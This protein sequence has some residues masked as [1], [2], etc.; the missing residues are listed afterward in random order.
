[1]N[2]CIYKMDGK[3]LCVPWYILT[4]FVLGWWGA[5]LACYMVSGRLTVNWVCTHLIPW[6]WFCTHTLSFFNPW[7]KPNIKHEYTLFFHPWIETSVTLA[8]ITLQKWVGI[9][10]KVGANML[11]ANLI[12][13]EIGTILLYCV[14][15]YIPC[16]NISGEKILFLNYNED[17]MTFGLM[18]IKSK[19]HFMLL[20][21]TAL[22][23]FFYLC[24]CF[25]WNYWCLLGG[26]LYLHGVWVVSI[27]KKGM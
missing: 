4:W 14:L 18:L 25:S 19:F 24:F 3:F 17:F 23:Q 1:M 20:L 26:W 9:W 16:F 8:F 21:L 2:T 7:L 13:S 12:G 6:W 22:L 5:R 10:Y 27:P 15:F 11:G